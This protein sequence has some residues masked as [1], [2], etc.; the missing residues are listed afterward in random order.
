MPNFR[1]A[2]CFKSFN[3]SIETR[4]GRSVRY[5]T[6]TIAANTCEVGNVIFCFNPNRSLIE[7]RVFTK[8]LS[9]LE[10]SVSE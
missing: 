5:C 6:W 10:E 3:K 2:I 9:F 4:N 1:L 8:T 7:G